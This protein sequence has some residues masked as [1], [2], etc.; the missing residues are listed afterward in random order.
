M[1]RL[2]SNLHA[3]TVESASLALEGI[4]DVQR[5]NSLSLGV[6]GVCDGIANN[7]FEEDLQDVAGFFI[8]E[9][10][11]TLDTTSASE[12]TN[13]RLGDTLDVVAKNLS[14]ALSTSFTESYTSVEIRMI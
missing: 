12:T 6:L 1:Q 9:T 4:D 10:R 14:V 11:D 3:E 8:D 5:G 7:V 2:G 13:G